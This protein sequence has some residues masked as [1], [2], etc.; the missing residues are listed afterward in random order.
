MVSMERITAVAWFADLIAFGTADGFVALRDL[1]SKKTVIRL[2]SGGG[3]GF[4]VGSDSIV[5]A[6]AE[7]P[8]DLAVKALSAV[9]MHSTGV[10]RLV[11]LP[12]PTAYT[13]LLVLL[14]DSL[15]VWQPRDVSIICD[16]F[17]CRLM[18]NFVNI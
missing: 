16:F 13:R 3:W 7:T 11:F 14:H 12:G 8:A 15:F 17:P 10:R 9:S 18:S 2:N 6:S 1:H 4:G 5:A